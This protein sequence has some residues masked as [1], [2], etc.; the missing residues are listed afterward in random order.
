MKRHIPPHN[1]PVLLSPSPDNHSLLNGQVNSA[2]YKTDWT[3]LSLVSEI[4]M[5]KLDSSATNQL[6]PI[7]VLCWLFV[8][9]AYVRAC[10]MDLG[11]PIATYII[12]KL[13]SWPLQFRE[14]NLSLTQLESPKD[15][16]THYG[17]V[18]ACSPLSLVSI[19][20]FVSFRLCR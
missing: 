12:S 5:N 1:H 17:P 15:S 6:L 3:H 9:T 20:M 4:W 13:P 11:E 7:P 18:L 2:G 10:E 19:G 14:L 8:P 16:S